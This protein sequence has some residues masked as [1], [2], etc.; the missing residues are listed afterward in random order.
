[1]NIVQIREAH[2]DNGIFSWPFPAS[3]RTIHFHHR[4]GGVPI[5]G[6]HPQMVLWMQNRVI[7]CLVTQRQSCTYTNIINLR[8]LRTHPTHGFPNIG[9][10]KT[11]SN[12]SVWPRPPPRRIS[13]ATPQDFEHLRV[14][15]QRC[16]PHN[17]H[18]NQLNNISFILGNR[19]HGPG[20]HQIY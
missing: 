1:M 14:L 4:L 19:T 11:Y 18:D 8:H 20:T 12:R 15:W 5:C 17:T 16:W 10:I 7:A 9:T 6:N 3:W 13:K 2:V